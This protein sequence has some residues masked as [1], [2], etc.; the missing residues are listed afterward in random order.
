MVTMV[1]VA[2]N[3]KFNTAALKKIIRPTIR[4]YLRSSFSFLKYFIP[5]SRVPPRAN[6]TAKDFHVTG[7]KEQ[8]G[9]KSTD[10]LGI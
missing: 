3:E 4:K 6:V 10:Q 5:A 9:N 2:Q 7:F 8:Q 1:I